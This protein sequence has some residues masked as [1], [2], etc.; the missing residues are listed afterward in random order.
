MQQ[1][2]E[3]EAVTQQQS[4]AVVKNMIRTSISEICYL[5]NLFDEDCFCKK[6]YAGIMINALH[7]MDTKEGSEP[8]IH[9]S[10][11]W[12]LTRWLEEGV[13]DAL[14]KRYLRGLV[15]AIYD[16]PE[17]KSQ[18]R[19]IE[20]YSYAFTYPDTQHIQLEVKQNNER[21][22][23]STDGVKNQ[24]VILLRT[25]ITLC[26]TLSPLPRERWITLQLYYYDDITPPDYQPAYFED[27]ADSSIR[28]GDSSFISDPFVIEAGRLRTPFHAMCMKVR[29]TES[30]LHQT[31][32]SSQHTAV[33]TQEPA[34]TDAQT[35]AVLRS[36]LAHDSVDPALLAS[37]FELKKPDL[38]RVLA[39]L[40]LLLPPS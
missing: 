5:R 31:D 9:N 32:P 17:N 11:A 36:I 12:Q 39:D 29:V 33:E 4:L 8:H 20:T 7:P 26:S 21:S 22:V 25:L 34:Q 1:K 18:S 13:F 2:S 30:T 24:A 23:V 16:N 19:L 40:G 15:F 37:E 3:V 10:E 38:D 6:N 35:D 28:P 27:T 14:E